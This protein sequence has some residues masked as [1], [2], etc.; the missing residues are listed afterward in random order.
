M[1]LHF[2][3]ARYLNLTSNDGLSGLSYAN[4][5]LIHGVESIREGREPG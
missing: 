2:R 5:R 3:A 1:S 4:A